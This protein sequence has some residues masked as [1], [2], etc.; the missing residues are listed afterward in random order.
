MGMGCPEEECEALSATSAQGTLKI[1]S[2]KNY[3]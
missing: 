1:N 3:M 2:W